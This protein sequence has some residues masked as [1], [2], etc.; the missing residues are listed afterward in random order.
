MFIAAT[1]STTSIVSQSNSC[2]QA[3]EPSEQEAAQWHFV[4]KGLVAV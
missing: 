2:S 4:Q 3:R 1:V